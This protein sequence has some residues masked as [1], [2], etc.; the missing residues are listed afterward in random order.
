MT[1]QAAGRPAKCTSLELPAIL[2]LAWIA[3]MSIPLALGEIGISWD[4]LNHHI[5]LGWVAEHPR[6]AQ[7]YLAASYQ[8]YQFPYLYWPV[9]RLSASGLSG[10]QAGALL[11]SLHLVAVPP[12]WMIARTCMPGHD[13]FDAAMRAFA[14]VLAFSTGVVLSMFDSSANDLLAAAPLVWAVA[15]ALLPWDIE[16]PTWLTVRRAVTLSGLF[17]GAAVACKLSNGPLALV[18]PALWVMP[19]GSLKDRMAYVVL[20]CAATLFG[21]TLVYGYWGWQLWAYFGNPIYPF[22]DHWFASLQAWLG[23]P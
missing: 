8:S 9:Y 5:Y 3:F 16:A 14:V 19:R 10:A 2:A 23:R 13:T 4:A 1:A 6:F 17:A 11:A 20:G 15:L 21:F 7:D 22:N 12:V 18:L